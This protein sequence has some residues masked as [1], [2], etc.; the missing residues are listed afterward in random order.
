MQ[1]TKE[2]KLILLNKF[3]EQMKAQMVLNEIDIRYFERAKL[4]AREGQLL[5]IENQITTLKPLKEQYE[6]KLRVIEDMKKELEK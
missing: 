5:Q 1:T 3:E 2:Q 4:T 6:I